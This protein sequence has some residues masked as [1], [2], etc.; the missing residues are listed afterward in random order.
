MRIYRS[1]VSVLSRLQGEAAQMPPLRRIEI[2][3]RMDDAAIVPQEQVADAP[4]M[5]VD[6]IRAFLMVEQAAEDRL[7]LARLHALDA[8]C[9][10]AVDVKQLGTRLGM[11]RHDRMRRTRQASGR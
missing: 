2:L 4:A 3:A 10:Q 11:G 9:H 7:A 6:E 8:R 5:G 1:Y